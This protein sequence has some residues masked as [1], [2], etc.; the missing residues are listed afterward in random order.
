MI[1]LA[2]VIVGCGNSVSGDPRS[3]TT[4]PSTMPSPVTETEGASTPEATP[5]AAAKESF[6]LRT[7]EIPLQRPSTTVGFGL[8]SLWLTDYGNYECNDTGGGA[9]ACAAPQKMFLRAMSPESYK[10]TA[11]IPFKGAMDASVAFG[12]DSV[13]VAVGQNPSSGGLF[14]IDPKTGEVLSRL[15][16]ESST[17]L[18]FGEGSVWVTSEA[19]GALLRVD[20][21]TGKMTANI[22]VSSG[23]L[24]G[25]AVGEGAVWVASWGPASEAGGQDRFG[26]KKL[27]RVDPGTN[28]VVAEIPIE[29]DAL[30]G[31]A[32]SVDVD[33]ESGAVWVT[34]VN[35]KLFRVDPENNRVVAGIEL[36]DYAWEVETFAGDAWTI[37]ETGVN[38]ASGASIQR[39]ARI[40]S[41]TNQVLG[42]MKAEDVSGLAAGKDALWFSS[43]SLTR[44]ETLKN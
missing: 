30:E 39:V 31:G 23:G 40:D 7:E 42:P 5:K 26:D 21:D 12:A 6:A 28:E 44:I 13:W 37:Y 32:S 17:A 11:T 8:G 18:A 33:E 1:L 20:P 19:R 38:D 9:A 10:V 27:V 35:G 24:S 36:G 43:D 34:S 15:P 29:Q 16:V 2:G 4:V 41:K 22:K 14:Q 25:V 3:T